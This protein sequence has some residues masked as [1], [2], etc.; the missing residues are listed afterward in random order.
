LSKEGFPLKTYDIPLA[1]GPNRI[2]IVAHN[3]IGDS[4]ALIHDVFQQ[5]E[6]DLVE[7]ALR[8]LAIGVDHYPG[9]SAK[10]DDLHYAA[11]DARDFARTAQVELRRQGQT[12]SVTELTSGAG[13]DLEPTRANI[14]AAL[15]ALDAASEKDT[16]VLFVAGH[17]ERKGD[18]YY[19]L[20]ADAIKKAGDG[21]GQGGNLLDWEAIQGVLTRTKGAHIL[22][23]DTCHSD[24][25]Y[26]TTLSRDALQ[27]FLAY[28]ATTPFSV[29]GAIEEDGHGYFTRAALAGLRGGAEDREEH[30][31]R[32][33]ELGAYIVREVRRS[34]QNRQEPG[35]YNGLGDVVLVR[36]GG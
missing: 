33:Y 19:F 13:G 36:R 4:Q 14:E 16:V 28:T 25:A 21:P 22:F 1:R 35:F 24:G 8:L 6:G 17:G 20:P 3:K 32:A 12:V 15:K 18:R 11:A 2:T 31:V 30:T 10:Y 26:H 9:A 29:T 5:G 34:T 23:V 7:G 27:R